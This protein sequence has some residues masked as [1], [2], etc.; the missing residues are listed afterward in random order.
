MRKRLRVMFALVA[1][2]VVATMAA[3][4]S[5]NH[6][7][8]TKAEIDF[9]SCR[10]VVATK[11]V[12]ADAIGDYVPDRIVVA[13]DRDGAAQLVIRAAKCRWLKATWG[14]H[15]GRTKRPIIVQVG[16]RIDRS[17]LPVAPDTP[18]EDELYS[19]FTVTNSPAFARAARSAGHARVFLSDGIRFRLGAAEKCGDPVETVISVRDDRA[20]SF[21][22]KGIVN[23]PGPGCEPEAVGPTA[24]WTVRYHVASVLVYRAH[25]QSLVESDTQLE[26]WAAR[27][28]RMNRMV[29]IAHFKT[30][31][32]T[33]GVIRANDTSPDAVIVPFRLDV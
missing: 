18:T 2:V 19:L 32:V 13:A 22:M 27:N 6:V 9:G 10:E 29:G 12:R 24:W 30:D 17:K 8:L 3:P 4:A 5:A 28:T 20:P 16:V 33:T 31:S 15:T 1:L 21:K 23:A 26:V 14:D 25:R 11:T 7:D